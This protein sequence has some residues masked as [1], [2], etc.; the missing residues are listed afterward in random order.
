[1]RRPIARDINQRKRAV[2]NLVATW[3]VG[4]PSFNPVIFG[5]S[6]WLD[7]ADTSTITSSSGSVSQWNDKSGNDRHVAQGV[8]ANQPTTGTRTV[9][10]LNGIDFNGSTNRLTASSATTLVNSWNGFY[11]VFGVCVADS[12]IG[13]KQILNA[14]LVVAPRPPQFLRIASGT[15]QTIR[16]ANFAGSQV[17]ATA[18]SA[19]NITLGA[20]ILLCAVLT[21]S[22]IR[23]GLNNVF[24]TEISATGGATATTN[25]FS[26]G[27]ANGTSFFDGIICELI[28]YPNYLDRNQ[29]RQITSYL[30]AKWNVAI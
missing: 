20:T 26:V 12:Q 17:V 4:Y 9:N 7:A 22:T 11:T 3:A 18:S 2:G 13:N 28:A 1:M 8:A 24:G 14:D 15:P 27:D 30:A 21:D 19:S 10:G 5:P 29:I 23:I 6:L 25:T 16:I